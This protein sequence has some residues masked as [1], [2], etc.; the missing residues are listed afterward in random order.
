MTFDKPQGE[1]IL[2]WRHYY[3]AEGALAYALGFGTT[4]RPGKFELY[5][6]MAKTFEILP[7]SPA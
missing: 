5:E 4:R 7:Q 2:N 1:G 3:L 6:S